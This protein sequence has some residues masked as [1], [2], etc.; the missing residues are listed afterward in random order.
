MQLASI[1]KLALVD[2]FY[3]WACGEFLTYIATVADLFT[4]MMGNVCM[5]STVPLIPYTNVFLSKG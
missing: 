2:G 1:L 4:F 3:K 5:R